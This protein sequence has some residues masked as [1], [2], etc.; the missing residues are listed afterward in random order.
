MHKI[1]FVCL[2]NICRSPAA[3]AIMQRLVERE[4]MGDRFE[5]DSAG[6]ISY[7]EGE[8]ADIRML[9]HA[10]SRGLT[11]SHR[12]RPIE[13][14]DFFRFDLIIGMDT[15]NINRLRTLAPTASAREK[16]RPMT[17]YCR[18]FKE[19]SVPD[20]YYGGAKGFELVLD[21]LEDACEGLLS[22]LLG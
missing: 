17:S 8:R 13:S 22:S 19:T 4:G 7:H 21:M 20:P 5:I 9:R 11:I 15:A 14:R 6:L 10:S 18:N 2:G 1:L 12:S 3:Q 16:V